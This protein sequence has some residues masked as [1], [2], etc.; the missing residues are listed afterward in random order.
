[1]KKK[2][3]LI[4]VISIFFSTI[5]GCWSRVETEN[6]AIATVIGIDKVT[7][8]GKEKYRVTLRIVRT[9]ALGLGQ[10]GGGG[11]TR[12]PSW[13]TDGYGETIQE[14]I[15]NIS[16]RSPREIFLA[17][18]KFIIFGEKLAAEGV[19]EV[20]DILLRHRDI[21]LRNW[22]IVVKGEA[23]KAMEA[24]AEL[25]QL[26]LEELTGLVE[27]TRP[28]VNKAVAVD[29]K[30]FAASMATP[31]RDIAVSKMETI[32]P[33]EETTQLD[34]EKAF[35]A[36]PNQPAGKVIQLTGSAVFKEDKL[37]GYLGDRE[38]GG[39]ALVLGEAKEAVIPVKL[40]GGFLSFVM[41][42]SEREIKS[43]VQDGEFIFDV[44]LNIEGDLGEHS[45]P[46]EITVEHI[47]EHE[48]RIADAIKKQV[49]DAIKAGQKDFQADIFGFGEILRRQHNPEWKKVKENWREV[50][51][52]VKVNVTVETK[53][54]RQGMISDTLKV[55]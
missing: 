50:F 34:I 6:L 2:I 48:K 39:L 53:I 1:M 19:Q 23:E 52:E 28:L 45:E 33:P 14:A 46:H 35:G 17:H 43:S 18:S 55:E 8:Q 37:V 5:M 42:R 12:T 15:N 54:R 16:T 38:T 32:V 29:L 22:I 49:E 21:R 9:G 44:K 47:P 41:T 40:E 3:A 30:D 20:L 27:Q 10:Q 25:E 4:I 7:I 13:L 11:V 31:G 51:P 24:E 26:I 36:T